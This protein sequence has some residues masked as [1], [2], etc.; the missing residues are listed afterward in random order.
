MSALRIKCNKAD[1]K[2]RG[3]PTERG[4]KR[5]L[6]RLDDHLG[7]K[8]GGAGHCPRSFTQTQRSECHTHLHK[9][10]SKSLTVQP[11]EVCCLFS[12]K[13]TE[14]RFPHTHTRCTCKLYSLVWSFSIRTHGLGL[15]KC[16]P[17]GE[18]AVIYVSYPKK[19]AL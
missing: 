12:Q 2:R 13:G 1:W 14:L 9:P 11:L 6:V 15:R 10:Q 17:K 19:S 7:G 5:E 18:R 3:R 16:P 8:K 4:N